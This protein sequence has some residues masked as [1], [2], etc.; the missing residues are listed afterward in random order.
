M[1]LKINSAHTG[2]N[3]AEPPSQQGV[4][5][6]VVAVS[7]GGVE[8]LIEYPA[9]MTHGGMTAE[10]R[11]ESRITDGLLRMRYIRQW[12]IHHSDVTRAS[13]ASNHRQLD[14]L[15]CSPACSG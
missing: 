10:A 11:K 8:T 4:R 14:C 15:S 7:L 12:I 2:L 3:N 9:T 1:S 6:I 5:L 13:S